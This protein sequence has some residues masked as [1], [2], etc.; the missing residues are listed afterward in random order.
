MA[1]SDGDIGHLMRGDGRA[2]TPG[3]IGEGRPLAGLPFSKA[4]GMRLHAAADGVAILSVAYRPDLVGDPDSAVLHGGVVT[5]LL[6]TAC[7]SAVMAAPVRLRTT[8]TLDL[9]IDYMRPARAGARVIARA[10]C[11]RLTRAI[12]FARAVAYHE[13]AEGGA[14]A[15]TDG[16]AGE[17]GEIVASAQGSFIIERA[18]KGR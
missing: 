13:D 4:L 18:E 7:G 8:A 6:D 15:G 11:Y 3:D 16:R 2:V 10:Q 12:A 14:Q 5:A 17:G 9:R 1:D